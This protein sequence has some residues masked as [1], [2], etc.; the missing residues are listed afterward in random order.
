MR[1]QVLGQAVAYEPQVWESRCVLGRALGWNAGGRSRVH[2]LPV[3][4]LLAHR[5]SAPTR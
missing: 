4:R 3:N 5:A 2:L 1:A